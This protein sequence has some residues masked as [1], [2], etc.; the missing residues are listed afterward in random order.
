L[1]RRRDDACV[2]ILDISHPCVRDFAFLKRPPTRN[3]TMKGFQELRDTVFPQQSFQNKVAVVIE[4][5]TFCLRGFGF[6]RHASSESGIMSTKGQYQAN[7]FLY[8]KD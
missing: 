5:E 6:V 1:R 7:R 2:I 4:E 8:A 3:R